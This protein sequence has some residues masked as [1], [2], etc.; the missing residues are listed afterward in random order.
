MDVLVMGDMDS[1]GER[2]LVSQGRADTDI[3]VAGHHGSKYSS[4]ALFLRAASPM[5]SVVSVGDNSYGHPTDEA[6]GRM[7]EY[8]DYVCRTD[9]SGNVTIRID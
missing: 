1:D 2:T 6:L 8:S 4:S 7:E 3:L 9:I 5:W